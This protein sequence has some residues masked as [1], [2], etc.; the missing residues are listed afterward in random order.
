MI[1]VRCKGPIV[2][3]SP[4]PC[5]KLI[6]YQFLP[7]LCT[8]LL[9][10]ATLTYQLHHYYMIYN[11]DPTTTFLQLLGNPN[12]ASSWD[13]L[14][15]KKLYQSQWGQDNGFPSSNYQILQSV[16]LQLRFATLACLFNLKTMEFH[17]CERDRAQKQQISSF[18]LIL[19]I[20]SP[21]SSFHNYKSNS[22][23]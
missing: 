22:F 18:Q 20:H 2:R 23:L 3:P 5:T 15:T 17:M 12:M 21:Y 1:I 8:K 10:L 11:F 14:R 6:L 9:H 7:L 19:D 4:S 16:L 13:L